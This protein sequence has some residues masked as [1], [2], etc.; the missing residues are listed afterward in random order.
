MC[1]AFCGV[2]EPCF[3]WTAFLT[4]SLCPSPCSFPQAPAL[5]FLSGENAE[6]RRSS[7]KGPVGV[8]GVSLVLS[9]LSLSRQGT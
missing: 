5:A 7:A 8:R 9:S 4:L 3:D 2:L 1:R 6:G